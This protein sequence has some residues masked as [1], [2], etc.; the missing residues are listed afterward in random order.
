MSS[1]DSIDW[2]LVLKKE[3][4]GMDDADLGE[5]QEIHLDN[6]ITKV[7]LIDKVTYKI[8]KNFVERFD[9]HTLLFKVTKEEAETRYKIKDEVWL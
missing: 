5:V 9:G 3:A 6:V 2:T 1:F 7:G 8:P 4:R